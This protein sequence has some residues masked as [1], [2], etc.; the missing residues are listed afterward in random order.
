MVSTPS[1]RA[2]FETTRRAW[3]A[4]MFAATASA[5]Q[6]PGLWRELIQNGTFDGWRSPSG[7]TPLG[8]AWIVRDGIL[9][10]R[11]YVHR[12]T[13]LWTEEE[14]GE[15]EL[16][17]EW[18]AEKGANSGIKYW[19]Q[20]AP[21]LVIVKENEKWRSVP[22]P[23]AAARDEPTLEYSIGVEYQMA[24]DEFEPTS[25]VRRDSRAGG[26]YGA[27]P[28]DPE[29]VRRH[30]EWNQSRILVKAG[31]VEHWLNGV[32]VVDTTPDALDLQLKEKSSY[33]IAKR[34]GPVALQYHQT[35]VSFRKMRIR[36]WE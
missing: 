7:K 28:P 22:G 11:P 9:S 26:I 19:V 25:L 3:F 33:K 35:V 32:R 15:F 21:T 31:R 24:D 34:R 18:K 17:W 27:F 2:P 4:G 10:V 13:D 5:Q 30:G 8:G 36:R 29:A 12:R 23:D 20:S 14:F 1:S 16:E 6:Q